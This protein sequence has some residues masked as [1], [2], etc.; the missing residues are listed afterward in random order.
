MNV[1]V[2]SFVIFVFFL[3]S[4]CLGHGISNSLRLTKVNFLE[5][6]FLGIATTATLLNLVYNFTTVDVANV[7]YCFITLYMFFFTLHILYSNKINLNNY[8]QEIIGIKNSIPHIISGL[9]F[10]FLYTF[11]VT[12]DLQSVAKNGGMLHAHI[13]LFTHI[14]NINQISSQQQLGNSPILLLGGINNFYHYGI[15][16]IPGIISS[17]TNISGLSLLIYG[18][19]PLGLLFMWSSIVSLIKSLTGFGVLSI[20]ICA[21]FAI[22]LS[23][24]SRAFF[25][26]NALFDFPYLI[27]A[28]PGVIYGIC[29]ILISI[30]QI[31]AHRDKFFISLIYFLF[32]LI[33]FRALFIP[34]YVFLCI[35][36]YLFLHKRC[37]T[38]LLA[39]I[40]LAST[41]VGAYLNVELYSY[42]QFVTSF[43][44]NGAGIHSDSKNRIILGMFLI[45][46]TLGGHLILL[47]GLVSTIRFI[48]SVKSIKFDKLL[49][50]LMLLIASYY[51]ALQ[52]GITLGGDMTELMHRPFVIFN[53][54][55]SILIL[56]SCLIALKPIASTITIT[57]LILIS[58]SYN[59]RPLGYPVDHNWHSLSYKIYVNPELIKI[60]DYLK[61]KN[62]ESGF[63]FLPINEASH[64]VFPESIITGLSGKAAFVSRPGHYIDN[65]PKKNGPIVKGNINYVKNLINC[66]LA[67]NDK[68]VIIIT[69]NTVPCLDQIENIGGHYLYK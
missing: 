11:T 40:I 34:I 52:L 41:L 42:E 65:D 28:S 54:L 14:S 43:N 2:S 17:I 62:H 16:V 1:I 3:H 6:I 21:V 44:S 69:Q 56:S 50:L 33:S 26:N 64:S 66:N 37:N 61:S 51:C 67:E 8:Q 19:I 35:F 9:I 32:L 15:Y 20:T 12:N 38:I 23:D 30:N 60:S 13:D 68:Q 39:A 22:I 25:L 36:I 27:N 55:F 47:A 59:Q 31:I 57:L 7:F 10:L 4:L 53:L 24:S 5:K 45:L 49:Y 48:P 63:V 29:I 58:V 46:Q 18:I